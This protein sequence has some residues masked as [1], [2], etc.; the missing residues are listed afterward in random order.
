MAKE[1]GKDRQAYW[2]K[3]IAEFE[4]SGG[5]HEE[6][7][8][9]RRLN[10]WTFRT[11]LYRVRAERGHRQS[12]RSKPRRLVEVKVAEAAVSGNTTAGVCIRAGNGVAVEFVGVPSPS[13]LAA[14]V[15]HLRGGEQ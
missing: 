3:V 11:W 6:F 2:R 14:V 10:V 12:S 4:R 7:A 8:R 13:Y 1:E 9:A 15:Y 5:T